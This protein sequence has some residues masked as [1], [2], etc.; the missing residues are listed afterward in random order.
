MCFCGIFIQLL[1][2]VLLLLNRFVPLAIVMLAPI[3]INI[4][5]FHGFLNPGD[6]Y[7]AVLLAV[8]LIILTN[9]HCQ[10]FTGVFKFK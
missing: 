9:H 7:M 8:L 1:G 6:G 2:G 10:A 3:V 4:V 5:L